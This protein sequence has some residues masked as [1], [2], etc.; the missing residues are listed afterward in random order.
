VAGQA[1]SAVRFVPL[2]ERGRLLSVPPPL[3]FL[4]AMDSFQLAQAV[5]KARSSA[6]NAT[7]HQVLPWCCLL[8]LIAR[9]ALSALAPF[10]IEPAE[11]PAFESL[12]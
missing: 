1:C 10:V 9:R 2:Q 6:G 4:E 12:P 5:G 8:H 3:F 7:V 11:A